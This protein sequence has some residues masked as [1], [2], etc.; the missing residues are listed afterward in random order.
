MPHFLGNR[1]HGK[2]F[3]VVEESEKE[4]LRKGDV[5]WGKLFAEMQH[6]A[7]LHFQD[8]MR[9][10]LRIGTNLIGWISY[11]CGGR[12]CIQRA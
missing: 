4:K 8:N 12:S 11:K 2:D 6:E 5:A 3:L 7:A 9:K 1:G 10:P